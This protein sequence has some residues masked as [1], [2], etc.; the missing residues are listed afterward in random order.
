MTKATSEQR[1]LSTGR[2]RRVVAPPMFVA[3]CLFGWLPRLLAADDSP[4]QSSAIPAADQCRSLH[5][6]EPALSFGFARRP[7]PSGSQCLFCGAGRGQTQSNQPAS[8]SETGIPHSQV[9]FWEGITITR[10][11]LSSSCAKIYMR[12][13]EIPASWYPE[14]S[15]T[16]PGFPGRYFIDEGSQL[17]PLDNARASVCDAIGIIVA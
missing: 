7:S 13:N 14:M 8:L 6:V 10:L 11:R 15:A 16:V 9:S 4:P 3:F 5:R 12:D 2:P 1:T 17:V